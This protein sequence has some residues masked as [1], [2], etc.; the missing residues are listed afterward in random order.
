MKKS[1]NEYNS[2][3]YAIYPTHEGVENKWEASNPKSLHP[4]DEV[5][6]KSLNPLEGR[7][8]ER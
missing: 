2:N 1:S 3:W 6:I 7:Y 5:I 8:A 4:T